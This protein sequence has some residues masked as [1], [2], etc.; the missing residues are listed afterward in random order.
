M[1]KLKQAVSGDVL[2]EEGAKNYNHSSF[3][4]KCSVLVPAL[5]VWPQTSQDV[6]AVVRLVRA[7]NRTFSVR[8]GGHGYA[9][10]AFKNNSVH[11]DMRQMRSFNFRRG[12]RYG[13]AKIGPG[14][15]MHDLMN[16]IPH[17]YQYTVGTCATVGVGGYFLHGGI[18]HRTH[19]LG[20]TTIY[21]M[22]VVTADGDL[23]TISEKSPHEGLWTAM[24]MAG[25]SFGVATSLSLRL[26][27]KPQRS[28]F[29]VPAF[30]SWEKLMSV[31]D[32]P[33][34]Q[35]HAENMPWLGLFRFDGVLPI[36][37][38]WLQVSTPGGIGA[39]ML[40]KLLAAIV[41]LATE[42]G[43]RV[44]LNATMKESDIVWGGPTLFTVK[45]AGSLGMLDS[46]KTFPAAAKVM[47]DFFKTRTDV[48]WWD[49]QGRGEDI[50]LDVSCTDDK[51]VRDLSQWIDQNRDIV[52]AGSRRYFNLP[53]DGTPLGDYWPNYVQLMAIKDR[54][55]PANF[56]DIWNGIRPSS[57]PVNLSESGTPL[58]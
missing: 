21:S 1:R 33:I 43:V 9:C 2:C 49:S 32:K 8:G 20:N 16:N 56:F 4:R 18:S 31:L 30:G 47:H 54:W 55:D 39:A 19:W 46:R 57:M 50:F 25:S 58:V 13:H 5:V 23:V 42:S 7:Y 45:R 51:T 29:W 38:Y 14:L 40:D 41:Q 17:G 28:F 24:R 6:Q 15:Q 48:C 27:A 26:P 35:N 34:A 53:L 10:S 44:D 12:S 52:Q 37:T 3:N 11:L 36:K 22:D